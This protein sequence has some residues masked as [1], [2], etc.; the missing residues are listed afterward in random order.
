M[1]IRIQDF[2][3]RYRPELPLILKKISFTIKEGE[4]VGIVGRIGG[5]KSYV[6]QTLLRIVESEQSS[7]Y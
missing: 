6:I 3:L 1:T 2:S 7:V 5:G 4:K